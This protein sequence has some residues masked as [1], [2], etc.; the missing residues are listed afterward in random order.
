[1]ATPAPWLTFRE[2][3]NRTWCR[4]N[5]VLMGDSAHTTHFSIGSG[6]KLAVQDAIALADVLP[7]DAAGLPVALA[8][9]D[10]RRRAALRPLQDA[11]H[12]SMGWFEDIDH[13]LSA[14]ADVVQFSHALSG[15]RGPQPLP[16]PVLDPLLKAAMTG[17]AR[18]ELA[19]HGLP[20]TPRAQHMQDAIK[21]L[22]E[23]DYGCARRTQRFLGW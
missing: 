18:P 21:D 11:A 14:D 1:M 10:E 7:P 3:T 16:G 4:G 22:A 5:L 12:A 20:L 17:R 8:A 13:L 19:G 23:R 9:Y 15:R 2:I 6:T